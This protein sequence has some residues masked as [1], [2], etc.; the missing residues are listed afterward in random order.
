MEDLTKGIANGLVFWK[1]SLTLLFIA[2]KLMNIIDW[3]WVWV[4][5]PI[6]TIWVLALALQLI[7]NILEAL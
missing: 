1:R 4:T 5:A 6:W 2:L 7:V 3:S